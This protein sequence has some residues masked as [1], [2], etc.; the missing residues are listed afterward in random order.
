VFRRL[1]HWPGVALLTAG[2]VL[3]SMSVLWISHDRQSPLAFGQSAI[4]TP[5]KPTAPP[6]NMATSTPPVIT[7]FVHPGAPSTAGLSDHL[8]IAATPPAVAGVG[9]PTRLTIPTLEVDAPA[10]AVLSDGQ[11]LRPPEDPMRVGWWIGSSPA[12]S[13][14]GST[15]VV[16]HVDTASAGPGAL[17]R[18]TELE[19]GTEII[20]RTADDATFRYIVNALIDYPKTEDLPPEL[21][22]TTGPAQLTLIT[23]GGQF[24][25]VTGSYDD[26]IVVT[27]SLAS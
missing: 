6:S 18:L 2:I 9:P 1:R 23:C 5:P 17:F 24:D 14:D 25:D 11:V 20:L 4:T 19:P 16:G 7:S 21:F 12:G 15:V 26:N 22:R 10:E 13:S 3:L 27:A 8:P